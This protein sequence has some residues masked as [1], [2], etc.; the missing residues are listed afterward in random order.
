MT[1]TIS[2]IITAGGSGRRFG[3]NKLLVLVK[4]RPLIIHTL[5][6]F[7]QAKSINEIVLLIKKNEI[8]QYQKIIN[9]AGLKVKIV[10]AASER[11]VS[12]YS[13]IKAAEGKYV[14]THDGNRP[15][16]PVK[17]I[18]KIAQEVVK[19][20]AVM[21]AVKPTATVKYSQQ[22]FI[23]RSLPRD[24]TWIAQTPQG[25][26]R[27]LIL[28][29]LEKAINNKQFL[30]TDD[31]EFVT[32][33]GYPVKIISGDDINIKITFPQDLLIAEQLLNFLKY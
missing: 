18:D 25:F 21:T 6:K 9:K 2:A 8:K 28:R 10:P 23:K 12:L 16:T 11:I 13:G 27:K 24:K 5:E 33:I 30:A 31:S 3:R 26:E 19:F 14:V 32:K 15:L 17:L 7:H 4:G 20:K 1:K 22:N 29:A